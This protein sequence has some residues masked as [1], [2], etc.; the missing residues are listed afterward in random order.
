MKNAGPLH[1]GSCIYIT[2]LADSAGKN[3][4][5]GRVDP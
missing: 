2:A 1:D 4:C 3:V 5:A